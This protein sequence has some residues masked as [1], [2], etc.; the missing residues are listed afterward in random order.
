[1]GILT[2]AEGRQACPCV[3]KF[4]FKGM[5]VL[6]YEEHL[7]YDIMRSMD[8]EGGSKDAAVSVDVF[9]GHWQTIQVRRA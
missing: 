3:F 2:I 1:M 5:D 7:D 4:I 9:Q 6:G 8:T